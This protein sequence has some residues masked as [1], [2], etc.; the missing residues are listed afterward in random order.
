M[1][2]DRKEAR[3]RLEAALTEIFQGALSEMDQLD[4]RFL[5]NTVKEM[6]REELIDAFSKLAASVPLVP[7]EHRDTFFTSK[8]EEERSTPHKD[9]R[10]DSMSFK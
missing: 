3:E 7:K 1:I 6:N 2:S 8:K 5:A 9:N 4:L 10:L